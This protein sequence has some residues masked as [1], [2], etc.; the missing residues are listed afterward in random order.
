[1]LKLF[2]SR[3]A[4][5]FFLCALAYQCTHAQAAWELDAA[6]GVAVAFRPELR[7]L[8]NGHVARFAVVRSIEAPSDWGRYRNNARVGLA[9]QTNNLGNPDEL[10]RQWTLGPQCDLALAGG[11]RTVLAVGLGAT[12]APYGPQNPQGFAIGTTFNLAAGLGLTGRLIRWPSGAG[13]DIKVLLNHQSNGSVI[14]P[15]LGTNV[16]TLGCVFRTASPPPTDAQPH[17]KWWLTNGS[18]GQYARLQ[19]DTR[20]RTAALHGRI[21][22][23]TRQRA[24]LGARDFV[25]D[26]GLD[27]RWSLD[28]RWGLNIGLGALAWQEAAI[29]PTGAIDTSSTSTSAIVSAVHLGAHAGPHLSFGRLT[30][31]LNYGRYLIAPSEYLAYYKLIWRYRL[32]PK[33]HLNME[34]WSHGFRADHPSFGLSYRLSSI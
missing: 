21:A 6:G 12:T 25:L 29:L 19:R 31:D 33:L 1:V 27:A 14:Q 23:G 34:L 30:L 22:L 28:P 18:P 11:L 20:P 17:S 15:N 9:L 24:A 8:I 7:R 10:G 2:K 16:M 4:L 5:A 26:F 3:F 32:N 13:L